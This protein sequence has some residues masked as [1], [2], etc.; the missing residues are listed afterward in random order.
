MQSPYLAIQA[1][2]SCAREPAAALA[3]FT[4]DLALKSMSN[5]H[6]TNNSHQ[7]L[8]QS[9]RESYANAYSITPAP[10]IDAFSNIIDIGPFASMFLVFERRRDAQMV[11]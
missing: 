3:S 6:A 5:C 4:C 1:G 11:N 8:I 10:R 7:Q 2:G 9:I